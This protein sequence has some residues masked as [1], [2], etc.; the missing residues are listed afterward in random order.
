MVRGETEQLFDKDGNLFI[1]QN[2]KFFSFILQYLRTGRNQQLQ[3]EILE[4]VMGI[5][6]RI[7]LDWSYFI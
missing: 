2:P 4:G 5:A 6:E 7:G 3:G 1:D